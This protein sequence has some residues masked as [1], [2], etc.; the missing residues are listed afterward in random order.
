[1][2]IKYSLIIATLLA[3]LVTSCRS[4][5]SPTPH[6]ES[7]TFIKETFRDSVVRIPA[8]QSSFQAA[9]GINELGNPVIK[10]VLNTQ[11]GKRAKTPKVRI[12]DQVLQVDCQCDSLDIYLK[13]KDTHITDMLQETV[14]VPTEK[15]LSV[16][17]QVQLWFGRVLLIGLAGIVVILLIT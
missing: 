10:E 14:F 6:R 4:L 12:K 7:K 1:M 2:K 9:L 8:D 3:L 5:K 16:W 13:L 15:P 11:T 17:Q